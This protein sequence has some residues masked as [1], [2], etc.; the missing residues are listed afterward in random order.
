MM[1]KQLIGK[2]LAVAIILGFFAGLIAVL[3]APLELR[4]MTK[5]Q[6]WPAR[7]GVITQSSASEVFSRRRGNRWTYVI[8]GRFLDTG[9]PFTLTRVRYDARRT[10]WLRWPH[11][12]S[13]GQW[14]STPLRPA[15]AK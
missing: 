4:R 6:A 12:R 3:A 5:A 1:A 2:A 14:T 8:R 11:T 10:A 15:R 13:A 7:R 9:D